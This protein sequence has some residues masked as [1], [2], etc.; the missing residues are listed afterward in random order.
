MHILEVI[1]KKKPKFQLKNAPK[2]SEY[3]FSRSS[4]RTDDIE[5]NS[6]AISD[7]V[8]EYID[9]F[10]TKDMTTIE[11]GGGSSSC[12]FAVN[13]KKHIC[14]NPDITGNEYIKSFLE[15]NNFDSS[16]LEFINQPSDKGLPLISDDIKIDCALI[17]GCHSY[18]I[19]IIDWHYIDLHL[20]KDGILIIDDTHMKSVGILCDV[21]DLENDYEF[22]FSIGVAKIYKKL[23][24]EKTIGWSQQIMNKK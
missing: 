6:H 23:K 9:K 10:V 18:P 3:F 22:I 4:H 7:K 12:I 20:K 11:T 14:V 5:R 21:L 19:P 2:G 15:K 1:K 13:A 17:D 16:T 24:D 8:L